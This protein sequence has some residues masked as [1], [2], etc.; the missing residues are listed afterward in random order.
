MTETLGDDLDGDAGGEEQAGVGVAEVVESGTADPGCSDDVS[1]GVGEHVGVDAA[2]VRPGE[3]EARRLVAGPPCE[4][5]LSLGHLVSS[6]GVDGVG[7][8]VDDSRLAGL[9]GVDGRF[10]AHRHPRLADPDTAHNPKVDDEGA[11]VG[12]ESWP[13]RIGCLRASIGPAICPYRTL[14]GRICP[15]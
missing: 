4:S 3:D 7:I 12:E 15:G 2:A 1:E 11:R 10:S 5:F 9:R 13:S 6:E 8:K 14:L